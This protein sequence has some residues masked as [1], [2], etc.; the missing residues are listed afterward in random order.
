MA[1]F[2]IYHYRAYDD[3][4]DQYFGDQLDFFNPWEDFQP[5][6]KTVVIVPKS[7]RWVNE[8]QTLTDQ[9]LTGQKHGHHLQ[10]RPQK[11][12]DYKHRIQLNVAGFDPQTI[13]TKVEN[14]KVIVEGKQEERQDDGDFNIRQFRKSYPIPEYA[15]IEHL[16]SYVTP[17]HMLVIEVPIKK[18]ESPQ[19]SA[20]QKKSDEKNLAQFGDHRDPLF[21]YGSFLGGSDFQ[22]RIVDKENNEKQLE[23]SMEMKSY[24]P[25]EIKVSVKN[26]EL[27]VKGE[28]RNDDVNHFERSFFFK[29][30]KLPPGTQ[31]EQ[32]QSFLTEDGQLKIQ[33]PFVAVQQDQMKAVE[34]QPQPTEEQK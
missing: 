25:E 28:H 12:H 23:M 21:D 29:S 4:V 19:P 34:S 24:R 31:I 30:I 2:P 18:P 13:Q 1:F 27:I 32:I 11:P 6:P 9:R 5:S 33:A 26:D 7:F 20:S 14:G 8:P 15:D 10:Q 3:P 17:N 22:P 16:T